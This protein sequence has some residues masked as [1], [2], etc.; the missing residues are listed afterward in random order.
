[1]LLYDS[2]VEGT[3]LLFDGIVELI[4]LSFEI[5]RIRNLKCAA[6]GGLGDVFLRPYRDQRF[7]YRFDLVV[8]SNQFGRR[9]CL[10]Q[11]AELRLTVL[12][13]CHRLSKR[14]VPQRI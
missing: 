13:V 14:R 6:Y 5:Q 1:M 2:R 7:Q 4:D 3:Q 12:E 10:C 9:L 8:A 11:R